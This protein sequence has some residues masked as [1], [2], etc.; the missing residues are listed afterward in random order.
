MLI[1]DTNVLSE[2]MKMTP[3]PRVSEWWT[4]QHSGDLFTTTVTVA[5]I[6]YGI[7]ILPKGRRRDSL[8]S[9]ADQVF[10]QDFDERILPFDEQAARAYS[11]IAATRRVRG[12]PISHFD[13]QIAAPQIAVPNPQKQRVAMQFRQ[14]HSE[15]RLAWLQV[16]DPPMLSPVR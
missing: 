7:E 16:P 11:R 2:I 9:E 15:F 10:T 5:E 8:R 6:L 12:C 14:L 4:Q 13:A 1:L 3:T